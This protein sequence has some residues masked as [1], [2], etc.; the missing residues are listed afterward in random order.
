MKKRKKKTVKN[1]YHNFQE[2]KMTSSEYLIFFDQPY[3]CLKY[4]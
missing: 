4:D 1:A 3:F 2:P